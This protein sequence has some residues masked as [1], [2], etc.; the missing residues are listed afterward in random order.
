MVNHHGANCTAQ[1]SSSRHFGVYRDRS[2]LFERSATTDDAYT[3]KTKFASFYL[4]ATIE[5]AQEHRT[6][7]A[8][9]PGNP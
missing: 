2:K 6:S 7:T 5:E 9:N 3:H 4:Y 1:K 8:A